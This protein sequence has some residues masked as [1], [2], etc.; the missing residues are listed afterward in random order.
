MADW[1][2]DK[3]GDDDDDDD[4]EEGDTPRVSTY[5]SVDHGE[6]ISSYLMN[7]LS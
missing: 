3:F 1:N 6:N 7:S 5:I 4:N 2:W